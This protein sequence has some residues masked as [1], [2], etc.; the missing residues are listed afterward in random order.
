M[1]LGEMTYGYCMPN[2]NLMG[3][4]ERL[5]LSDRKSRLLGKKGLDCDDDFLAK[6]GWMTRLPVI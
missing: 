2:I 5:N 3:G 4:R 6:S 1:A